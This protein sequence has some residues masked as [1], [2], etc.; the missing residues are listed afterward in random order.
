[1]PR[2]NEI[3]RGCPFHPRCPSAFAPCTSERPQLRP[4]GSSE[5]ACWLYEGA[6]APAGAA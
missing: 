1:M 2:V 5:V 6:L 4:V 3:P